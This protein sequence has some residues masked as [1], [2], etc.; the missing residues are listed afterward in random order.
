MSSIT[1]SNDKSQASGSAQDNI[2]DI[3]AGIMSIAP[4]LGKMM[5]AMAMN[6]IRE[7][8]NVV[9]GICYVLYKMREQKR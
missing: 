1:G 5:V 4:A 6:S 3:V 2:S 9:K 7:D 8:N